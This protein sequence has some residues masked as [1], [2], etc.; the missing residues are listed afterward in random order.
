MEESC[1]SPEEENRCKSVLHAGE[2]VLLVVKPRVEMDVVDAWFCRISGGIVLGIMVQV[3]WQVQ[4]MWWLVLLMTLPGWALGVYVLLSPRLYRRNRGRTVYLLTEQRVL[5][6]ESRALSGERVVAYPLRPDPV[7]EVL[8]RENGYGDIVFAYEQRWQLGPRIHRG[9]SPVGFIDVPEVDQ[10]AQM[11]AEQVAAM[12]SASPLPAAQPPA[13]AG[14]STETD[15]WGNSVAMNSSRGV[16]IGAGSLFLVVCGIFLGLGIW[17][18]VQDARFEKSAVR[19]TAIV[20]SVRQEV[21]KHTDNHH[22]RRH[23]SNGGVTIHVDGKQASRSYHVYYPMLEY[24]DASGVV[25]HV[26][27]TNGSTEYNYPIGHRLE[28]MYPPTEPAAMR[29]CDSGP[30]LGMIFTFIGA[31]GSII[32]AGVLAGGLMMKKS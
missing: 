6:L 29:L 23:R 28:I 13:W 8:R 2:R 14:L 9:P 15:S 30:G 22:R 10:V 12:P 18:Q 7:R 26:E 3:L 24:T 19:T 17:F 27:S 16:M 21:R 31:F 11:I 1:L 20:V 32:G 5:V 25:H 4:G